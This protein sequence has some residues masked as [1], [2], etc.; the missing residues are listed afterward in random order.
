VAETER[1]GGQI[2]PLPGL[3]NPYVDAVEGKVPREIVDFEMMTDPYANMLPSTSNVNAARTISR[4][5]Q[6]WSNGN[7]LKMAISAVLVLVLILPFVLLVMSQI[8]R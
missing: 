2:E 6:A 8:T 1:S 5:V 7:R 3:V 4:G